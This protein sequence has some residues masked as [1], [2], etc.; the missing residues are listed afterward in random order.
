[1][2]GAVRPTHGSAQRLSDLCYL[3]PAR[4]TR[5]GPGVG[6]ARGNRG[7][8]N[9]RERVYAVCMQPTLQ[10]TLGVAR[11]YFTETH[12]IGQQ[13]GKIAGLLAELQVLC[14]C[15]ESSGPPSSCVVGCG[16]VTGRAHT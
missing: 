4:A 14:R 13:T 12:R 2:D 16:R 1:M 8:H 6:A 10:A 3:D 9:L 11:I 15:R 5:W 7:S